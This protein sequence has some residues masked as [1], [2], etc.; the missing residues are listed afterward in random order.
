MH[1]ANKQWRDDEEE[2]DQIIAVRLPWNLLIWY[3]VVILD[4][5]LIMIKEWKVHKSN[6]VHVHLQI[7]GHF[8]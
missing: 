2:I 1:D 4:Q 7:V 5:T 3:F 8:D 6:E